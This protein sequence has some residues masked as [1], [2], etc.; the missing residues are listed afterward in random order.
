MAAS[1]PVIVS[2]QVGIHHEIAE[3]AAGVV[4]ECD[5]AQ[6]TRALI[7]LLNDAVL[8][9]SMGRNGRRLVENRYSLEAVTDEV[10]CL[11]EGVTH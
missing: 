10:L 2:D 7:L 3:A 6:L 8:R 5:V 11:Y 9:R 1:A 4:V